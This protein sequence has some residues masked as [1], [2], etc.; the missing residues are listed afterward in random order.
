[1]DKSKLVIVMADQAWTLAAL[2][3]ACA[4]SRRNQTDVAL[5]KMIPVRHPALLGTAAGSL[6][7]TSKDEQALADM[8]ATAE[9]YGVSLDV[10]VCQYVNFWNAV[11]NAAE[12][13]QVTAVI[14]HI[15][16]SPLPYWRTMRRRLLRRQ[17][18]RQGQLLITLDDLTPSLTWT[19][20]IT[21]QEE[22]AIQLKQ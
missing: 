14:T 2:H 13:L 8:V 12:Q 5:L 18:G 7:F 1:M 15:P 6:N 19:P 20:S 9:D 11:V 17:L 10:E 22:T 4:I 3:L 16:P 21:L